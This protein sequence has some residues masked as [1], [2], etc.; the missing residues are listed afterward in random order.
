LTC[1]VESVPLW[2]ARNYGFFAVYAET[3]VLEMVLEIGLDEKIVHWV[4]TEDVTAAEQQC[5]ISSR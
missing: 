5:R 1:E 4:I 2:E 3:A